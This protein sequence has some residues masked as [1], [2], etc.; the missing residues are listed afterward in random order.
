MY[1]HWLSLMGL[2]HCKSIRWNLIENQLSIDH[3][4]HGHHNKN[5]T[6]GWNVFSGDC[7]PRISVPR[8]ISGWSCFLEVSQKSPCK[9]QKYH[10]QGEIA[11]CNG[12]SEFV[13]CNL[14]GSPLS[15]SEQRASL[16]TLLSGSLHY[17]LQRGIIGLSVPLY[18][19]KHLIT[20]KYMSLLMT[21]WIYRW[22]GG[23]TVIKL[24]HRH[25]QRFLQ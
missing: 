13:S 23:K 3:L 15:G 21:K 19:L 6:T 25:I 22:A 14:P 17:L 5:W 4:C 10:R 11:E 12:N 16:I 7:A 24:K 2:G 20:N 9:K 18:N 1:Q 8:I